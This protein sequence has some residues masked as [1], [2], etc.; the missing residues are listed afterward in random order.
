[1]EVFIKESLY[2]LDYKDEIVDQIFSSDD[3]LTPGYAYNINIEESNTGYSNLTFTMPTKISPTPTNVEDTLEE[4]KLLDNPKLKLLTPLVKLRYNRKVLYTGKEPITVQEPTGYGDTTVFVEKIYSPDYPNNIIEDYTMD[5][6]VQPID[7]KRSGSEVSLDF[8]AIDYPRFNLSKK[9]F[10]T[11]VSDETIT[12][13]D[14]SIYEKKPMDVPGSVKYIQWTDDLSKTIGATDVPLEWDAEKSTSYP[15]SEDEIAELLKQT[16]VW[17]Y[18]ILSTVFY[19][20]ISSTGRFQGTLYNKGDYLTLQMYEKKLTDAVDVSTIEIENKN[21]VLMKYTWNGSK[22]IQTSIISDSE[23]LVYQKY[24]TDENY[25]GDYT[26]L[27]ILESENPNPTANKWGIVVTPSQVSLDF[28]GYEWLCLEQGHSYLT[29]N[30]A[31]NYLSYILE[32]TN[33]SIKNTSERFLG[34]FLDKNFPASAKENDYLI[35]KKVNSD[36]YYKGIITIDTDIP[37]QSVFPTSNVENGDWCFVI[38]KINDKIV[39]SWKYT[40]NNGSWFLDWSDRDSISTY[41]YE[42]QSSKWVD[43]TT[44]AWT[45]SIDKKTGVLYDV[46]EVTTEIATPENTSSLFETTELRAA[47]SL[48]D[49]NCYNAITEISKV[50]QVYPIYDC[51]NRTVSLKLFSGKNYGLSYKLGWALENTGVKTDGEKVITKLRCFG[52]QYTQGDTVINIGARARQKQA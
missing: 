13:D 19:W 4:Y 23:I 12:R 10:G 27:N 37:D 11:T 29:P 46:D 34:T 47:L 21:F 52:G 7:K 51:I 24:I 44:E 26:S 42:F 38:E 48:S 16:S 25:I 6:I 40:L 20:P 22:W 31:C 49:S 17:S 45:H 33:W 30:N 39:N 1:M 32:T 50:F 9:K 2:V 5:Y 41:F 14:W 15:I 18:G 43:V 3:H 8:N 35:Y 28:Y 36:D